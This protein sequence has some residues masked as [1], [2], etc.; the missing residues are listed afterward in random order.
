[1]QPQKFGRIVMF[2]SMAARTGGKNIAHYAAS[3][4]GILGLMRSLAVESA[5]DNIRVNAIS[6]VLT[7]TPMPRAVVSDEYMQSRKADIPLGRIGDVQDMADGCM[8][9]LSDDNADIKR[10]F[11]SVRG[12]KLGVGG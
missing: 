5:L 6:P 7:D 2:S 10:P 3:K 8:F 11:P 12:I 1:M 4:G 9:L